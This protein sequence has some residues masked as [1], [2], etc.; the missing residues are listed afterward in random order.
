MVRLIALA[1]LAYLLYRWLKPKTAKTENKQTRAKSK[2]AARLV[3]DEMVKD[4][5]CGA[6]FPAASGVPAKIGGQKLLFCSDKCRDE[7]I[8][9]RKG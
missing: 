2:P 8:K 4:P 3:E 7:Y 5:Q 9:T 1:V 6:W